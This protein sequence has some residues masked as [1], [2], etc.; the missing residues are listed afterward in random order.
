M[1]IAQTVC[2]WDTTTDT[3]AADA[4]LR[5]GDLVGAD[6]REQFRTSRPERPPTS[7]TEPRQ[8]DARVVVVDVTPG[9][10]T[11]DQGYI[12]PDTTNSAWRTYT[13]TLH[14]A[15]DNGW[16]SPDQRQY[17]KTELRRTND[18]WAAAQLTIKEMP[19]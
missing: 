2:Q 19:S 16:V 17:V 18:R 8:H 3:G 4:V 5:A 1:S 10:H 13:V 14:W 12:V 6:L 9:G 7:W 15:G 11:N